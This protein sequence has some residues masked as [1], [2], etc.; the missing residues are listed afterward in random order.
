MM[1]RMLKEESNELAELWSE[2][3]GLEDF[4]IEILRCAPQNFSHH[5]RDVDE[6]RILV[7]N[8]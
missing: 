6:E 2:S 1:D 8:H 7:S 5:P 4:R 3:G